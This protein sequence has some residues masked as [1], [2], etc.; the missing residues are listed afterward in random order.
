MA[1]RPARPE[2]ES[3]EIEV[4]ITPEMIEAG[5]EAYYAL[6]GEGWENPGEWALKPALSAIYE[7]MYLSSPR[8]EHDAKSCL[9]G[10]SGLRF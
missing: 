1:D 8:N 10:G 3:S 2:A 6:A 5:V 7:A 4:E 9:Q